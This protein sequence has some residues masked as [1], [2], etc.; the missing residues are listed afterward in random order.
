MHKN[1]ERPLIGIV[2]SIVAR[3]QFVRQEL[4]THLGRVG[5]E[6]VDFRTPAHVQDRTAGVSILSS[7]LS[8][9]ATF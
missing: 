1:G 3:V 6:L 9:P 2:Q 5:L 4:A 7:F 8:R